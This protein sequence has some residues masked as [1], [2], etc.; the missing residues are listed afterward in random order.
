MKEK[1]VK[2]ELSSVNQPYL[3]HVR[4][5]ACKETNI[6]SLL[7]GMPPELAYLYG[8]ANGYLGL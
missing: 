1:V 6:A 4:G 3:S 5:I 8:A 2:I 7:L